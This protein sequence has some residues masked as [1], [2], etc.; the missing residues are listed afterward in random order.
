M[1]RNGPP[2]WPV[3]EHWDVDNTVSYHDECDGAFEPAIPERLHAGEVEPNW[4]H[5]TA[6]QRHTQSVQWRESAAFAGRPSRRADDERAPQSCTRD[7]L[8]APRQYDR[9]FETVGSAHSG[10]HRD[11]NQ[12]K[13]PEQPHWQTPWR[14]L[15]LATASERAPML[16]REAVKPWPNRARTN[17]SSR[18][19]W[20]HSELQARIQASWRPKTGHLSYSFA[21]DSKCEGDVS[22]CASN[23][24][25]HF[26]SESNAQTAPRPRGRE[27]N[28]VRLHQRHW[29]QAHLG[30]TTFKCVT[31]P[32]GLDPK[33]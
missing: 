13:Q 3:R 30:R 18:E 32:L 14:P 20:P 2:R 24:A 8:A 31:L 5:R 23:E 25:S 7:W 17:R 27:S 11:N 28:D 29:P 19:D 6:E 22:E 16:K 33:E 26:S 4:R 9:R 12:H 15:Q 10:D 1:E 21:G